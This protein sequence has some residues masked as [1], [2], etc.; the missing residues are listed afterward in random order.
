MGESCLGALIGA[1]SSFFFMC[2]LTECFGAFGTLLKDA[3]R[4]EIEIENEMR[5]E[6]KFGNLASSH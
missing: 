2:I 6:I 5:I 4:A 3:E 1:W